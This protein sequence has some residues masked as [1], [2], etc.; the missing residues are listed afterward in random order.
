MPCGRSDSTITSV[1][2]LVRAT[3]R[4]DPSST[5]RR[6]HAPLATRCARRSASGIVRSSHV[7]VVRTTIRPSGSSQRSHNGQFSVVR[8]VDLARTGPRPR[9]PAGTADDDARAGGGGTRAALPSRRRRQQRSRRSC[10]ARAERTSMAGHAESSP[11]TP[12]CSSSPAI[13]RDRTPHDSVRCATSIGDVPNWSSPRN[14]K[15]A[16]R[17]RGPR[18]PTRRASANRA[19][20]Q[21]RHARRDRSRDGRC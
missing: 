10:A 19:A 16:C 1:I 11:S 13:R 17:R 12:G 2:G 14:S 6:P 5:R 4:S 18:T 21:R 3:K 9:M 7:A 8:C 20:D 15:P